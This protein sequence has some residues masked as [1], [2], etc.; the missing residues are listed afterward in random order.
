MS[1]CMSGS[2]VSRDNE[3]FDEGQFS[4]ADDEVAEV[5]IM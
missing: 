3:D 5:R 1:D 4:D 2:D